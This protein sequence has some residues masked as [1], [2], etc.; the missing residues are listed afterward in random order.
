[1]AASVRERHPAIGLARQQRR[2]RGAREL[3]RPGAG[4]GRGADPDQ[5]PRIGLVP[6]R[7]PSRARVRGA[8]A[9]RERRLGRGDGRRSGPYSASKHAQLAFSRSVARELQPRGIHVHTINPGFVHTEGFPQDWLLRR[10]YG[11]VVVGPE[12]VADR[13]MRAIERDRARDL[14][15][16]LVSGGRD[17]AGSP[18]GRVP[19]RPGATGEPLAG[20]SFARARAP[21]RASRSCLRRAPRRSARAAGRSPAPAAG[22]ARRR[23][24]AARPARSRARRLD[25]PPSSGAPAKTSASSAHGSV[26]RRK[27]WIARGE[28]SVGRL[29]AE[30]GAGVAASARSRPE[31]PQVRRRRPR[32]GGTPDESTS[33][34]RSSPALDP[35]SGASRPSSSSAPIAG[36]RE[37]HELG[38]DPLAAPARVTSPACSRTSA[39]SPGRA[40]SRARPRAGPRAAAAADR[41]SKTLGETRPEDASRRGRHGRRT[42][43]RPRRP[44]SGTAIALTVKSRVAR[45]SSIVPRQ[46]REVDRPPVRRARPARRRAAPRAGTALRPSASRRRARPPSGSRQATSRSIELAAEQLVADGAAD[47]PGLLAGAGPP[48]RAHASSDHAAA[49]ASGPTRSRRRARS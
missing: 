1:M 39:P 42:D 16:A 27:R 25:S 8:L 10:R 29:G 32:R 28:P 6:A 24:G 5:L 21:P 46:R 2:G 33:A 41:P 47:D 9:P 18:S 49:R 22:R 19:P 43:R 7:V 36:G 17:R 38:E 14:R 26:A 35:P 13:I 30:Q 23:A 44:P 45:S 20:F 48:A 31:P 3:P 4:A 12:Y 34:A 37:P 40:G 11:R 15:P